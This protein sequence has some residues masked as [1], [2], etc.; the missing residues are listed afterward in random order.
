[1]KFSSK[2]LEGYL[3]VAIGLLTIVAFIIL[4]GSGYGVDTGTIV[5]SILLIILTGVNILN[6]IILLRVVEA[7]T[8]GEF[9]ATE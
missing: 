2:Y 8:D 6:S 7:L 5:L 4:S 9:D 3:A 1:M